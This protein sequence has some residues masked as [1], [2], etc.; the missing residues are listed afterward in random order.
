MGAC[1]N[2]ISPASPAT[3]RQLSVPSELGSRAAKS[4]IRLIELEQKL[5]G[6]PDLEAGFLKLQAW[7]KE[8]TTYVARLEA[9]TK[10]LE[11]TVNEQHSVIQHQQAHISRLGRRALLQK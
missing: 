9:H 6:L 11:A 2:T 5:A 8:L 4:A 3:G 1:V 10:H 7:T